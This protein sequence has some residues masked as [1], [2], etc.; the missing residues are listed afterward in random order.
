M[1]TRY[2]RETPN[3]QSH[4]KTGGAKTVF[5]LL[6]TVALLCGGVLFTLKTISDRKE[7]EREAIIYSDQF[8]EGIS[9]GGVDVGGLT[10]AQAEDLLASK[11]NEAIGEMSFTLRCNNNSFLADKS[12]F[13]VSSNANE[14]LRTAFALIRQGTL[15]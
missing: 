5:I 3:R 4:R 7:K 14:Q 10:Y 6:L 11:Q 13:S 9:V 1:E 2:Q 8:H 15:E 12:Y